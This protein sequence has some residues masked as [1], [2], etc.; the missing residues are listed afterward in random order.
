[1][2]GT[3]PVP[4]PASPGSRPSLLVDLTG[5]RL[6]LTGASADS[7]IGHALAVVLAGLGARLVLTARREGPLAATRAALTDPERHTLAPFDLGELDAIPGW[8][9]G[10]AADGGALDG[11]V[12]AASVQ[13]YSVLR[14]V[15]AAAFDRSF[16]LNTGAALMLARGFQHKGVGVGTGGSLVFIGSAAGL[17]GQKGR[18]LYAASKAA[19]ASVARSLALELA[20]RGIRVNLVAPAVVDGPQARRQMAMLPTEQGEALRAAHPLGFGRPEDVAA[21]VAFLLSDAARWITGIVMPVDGGYS[22]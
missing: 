20:G 11:V 13:G 4:T 1:M 15:D 12:H 16:H 14:G 18:A 6:L 10:L 5:R 8:M 2:N 9:K 22:A 7:A 3:F 21:A 19:L 17:S